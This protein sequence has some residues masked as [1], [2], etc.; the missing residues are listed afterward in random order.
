MLKSLS[1]FTLTQFCL[2]QCKDEYKALFY[3]FL[4]ILQNSSV[5]VCFQFFPPQRKIQ[6]Y[7]PVLESCEFKFSA[8]HEIT[9]QFINIFSVFHL[10]FNL[11]NRNG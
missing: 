2:L 3:P 5:Y 9:A 11:E 1:I 6:T 10:F 7:L 8:S 4:Q